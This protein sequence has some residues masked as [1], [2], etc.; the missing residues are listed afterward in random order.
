MRVLVCGARELDQAGEALVRE[1]MLK[2]LGKQTGELAPFVQ[3]IHGACKGVDMFAARV[4]AE[5]G[6]RVLAFPPN[7]VK[8]GKEAFTKRNTEMVNMA[9][10]LVLAFPGRDS[11]GT[12]D[13][14]NKARAKKLKIAIVRL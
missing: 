14:I 9:P 12:F 6:W 4:A 5:H 13:T 1:A 10:D 7:K 2:H 8:Y 3:I 11:A